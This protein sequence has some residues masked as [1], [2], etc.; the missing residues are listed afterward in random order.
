MFIYLCVM[1]QIY[2]P[3]NENFDKNGNMVIDTNYVS[4][5]GF[6]EGLAFVWKDYPWRNEAHPVCIDK[7]GNIVI[8]E[9]PKVGGEIDHLFFS[10]GLACI[11][12]NDKY[13]YIDKTGKFVIEPQFD[14]AQNFSDGLALIAYEKEISLYADGDES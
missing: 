14:F 3:G 7:K 1:V 9:L 11:K 4:I 6:H 13:G 12:V 10:E 2:V 8:E 5:N